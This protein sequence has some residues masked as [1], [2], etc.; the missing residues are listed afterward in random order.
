MT[1]TAAAFALGSP[2]APRSLVW[3]AWTR[4]DEFHLAARR[5][6]EAVELTAFATGRWR[7]DVNGEVGRWHRPTQAVPGWTRGPSVFLPGWDAAAWGKEAGAESVI[8]LNAPADGLVTRLDVWFAIPGAEER[9]WRQTLP[10][11]ARIVLSLP[12]RRAGSIRMVRDDAPTT[13]DDDARTEGL[14]T[15]STDQAGLPSFREIPG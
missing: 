9:R 5:G 14:V 1:D 10:K 7:I 2:D 3:R 6:T 12:L 11:T 13:D 8:W 4:D 15:V